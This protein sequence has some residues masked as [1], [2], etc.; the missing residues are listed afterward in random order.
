MAKS[1]NSFA[2]LDDDVEDD[3]VEA[4]FNRIVNKAVDSMIHAHKEDETS[5]RNGS[6]SRK[7]KGHWDGSHDN[8]NGWDFD[9]QGGG[10]LEWNHSRDSYGSGYAVGD[11]KSLDWGQGHGKDS[12]VEN[13][14][15]DNVN[16]AFGGENG[17]DNVNEASGGENGWGNVNE[18]SGGE[19]GWGNVNEAS[20]GEN[21]WGN[22]QTVND[23][24]GWQEV[25]KSQGKG[26]AY[27]DR[28]FGYKHGYKNGNDVEEKRG[29]GEQVQDY[30]AAD[31]QRQYRNGNQRYGGERRGY[32][33]QG[34][35][36]NA[37]DG[38]RYRNGRRGYDGERRGNEDK[39]QDTNANSEQHSM[40]VDV[41]EDNRAGGEDR[42]YRNGNRNYGGER[43]GY[44][45]NRE[46]GRTDDG[47]DFRAV[48]INGS[49]GDAEMDWEASKAAEIEEHN[50]T[51]EV[52][53]DTR[54]P[55]DTEVQKKKTELELKKKEEM[56]EAALMTLDQY[57][58]LLFEKKQALNSQKTELRKVAIDKE[59]EGMRVIE[60][61][62]VAID[63][64]WKSAKDKQ[65]KKNSPKN[66]AT[67]TSKTEDN[68][69]VTE[70]DVN[71]I[72]EQEKLQNDGSLEKKE[73]SCKFVAVEVH[74][75]F[76]QT[77]HRRS[78]GGRG[79]GRGGRGEQ[80]S[81]ND[82]T[83]SD[84]AGR[85]PARAPASRRPRIPTDKDFPVLGATLPTPVKHST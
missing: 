51:E 84:T 3:D 74:E 10:G 64:I 76:K 80:G 36:N 44:G 22:I 30:G 75:I 34:Q 85:T 77:F 40:E 28:A 19:N 49:G 62:P 7:G 67:E 17:W 60:K 50:I 9:V 31:G 35:G 59:L 61:K 42:K 1:V 2:L 55:E 83:N 82:R 56:K 14:W 21:V 18:A 11:G 23:D 26:Y 72:S 66:Q 25:S 71:L 15:G 32:V 4:L 57:E 65:K 33:N 16:E 6:G 63:E 24:A 81:F 47:H 79:Q 70:S 41:T 5:A 27:N 20:G 37:A 43:R 78:S 38:R 73:K 53:E 12:G 29:Y 8:R 39:V 54:V 58:K 48:H 13:G 52:S 69:E 46:R 45:G 68:G